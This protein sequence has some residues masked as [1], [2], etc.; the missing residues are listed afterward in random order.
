[1]IGG[2][3]KKFRRPS[4]VLIPHLNLLQAQIET[5]CAGFSKM[6]KKLFMVIQQRDD[7]I[8]EMQTKASEVRVVYLGFGMGWWWDGGL[9]L[10]VEWWPVELDG[11]CHQ[12]RVPMCTRFRGWP[13]GCPLQVH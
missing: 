5:V 7:L 11:L 9:G 2:V 8:R 6:H 10:G 4:D 1:M 13:R 12:A 3:Q